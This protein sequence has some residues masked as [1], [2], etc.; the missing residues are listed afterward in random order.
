MNI[1]FSLCETN[2][3]YLNMTIFVNVAF[4]FRN[5]SQI[6]SVYSHLFLPDADVIYVEVDIKISHSGQ[7]HFHLHSVLWG[8]Y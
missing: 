7:T 6:I 8:K 5:L 4:S 1:K 3:I 2:W